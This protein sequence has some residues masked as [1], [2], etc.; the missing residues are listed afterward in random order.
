MTQTAAT[1][2]AKL[3]GA[4]AGADAPRQAHDAVLGVQPLVAGEPSLAETLAALLAF[5][6]GEG[7]KVL[8]RGGGT[9]TGM[10][11]SPTGGAIAC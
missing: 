4:G 9:H 7:L 2:Q 10:G 1:L 6:D 11:F 3:D 5:T 8:P